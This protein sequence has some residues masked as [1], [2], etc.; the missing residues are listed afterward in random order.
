MFRNL[1]AF[2]A[3]L[4]LFIPV[5][6]QRSAELDSSPVQL[7]VTVVY[8]NEQPLTVPVRVQLVN[9]SH[10]V[11]VEERFT[12][13]IGQVTFRS[14]Q[15][16]S[17]KVK[18]GG[19][20]IIET[21]ENIEVEP[22]KTTQSTIHVRAA[23]EADSNKSPGGTVTLA[24][25][26]VPE[27]A[28]KEFDRGTEALDY[29][30]LT[31]AA[32]HFEKAARI[33]PTYASAFNN[34]GVIAARQKDLKM[35]RTYF[36]KAVSVDTHLSDAYLNLGKLDLSEQKFQ[37]AKQPLER[38]LDI[39]P[40]NLEAMMMMANC[41]LITGQNESAIA[42]ARKIHALP[43]EKFAASHLVAARALE[44]SHRPDQAI[45]EYR[46]FLQE[47]PGSEFAHD[48]R[49]ALARLRPTN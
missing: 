20:G 28:R 35:A 9:A 5:E 26:N 27:K 13:S 7:R 24:N 15:P 25:L 2:A 32:K 39:E 17:Y 12:D 37:D 8:T 42:Y 41:E 44:A 29:S 19:I 22:H 21:S 46:I 18:V 11:T 30:D 23:Q 38:A 4:L 14:V 36:E 34:L 47:A 1:A 43:H 10:M 31:E 49:E 16:G 48:A 3:A 6:A 40:Q 33:Y 45:E